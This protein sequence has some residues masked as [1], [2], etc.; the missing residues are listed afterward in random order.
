MSAVP[1]DEYVPLDYPEWVGRFYAV[2]ETILNF[3]AWGISR[4]GALKL[5]RQAVNDYE[6]AK[7][8]A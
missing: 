3:E 4:D 5:A 8:A 1:Q 7:A 2:I 6:Q